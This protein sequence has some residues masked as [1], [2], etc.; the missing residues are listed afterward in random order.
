MTAPNVLV[1][2]GYGVNC[3]HETQHA[4]GLAG[5]KAE[6]V[7]VNDLIDAP[8]RLAAYQI[9][10][11]P[12]GFSFGDDIAAGR[13]LANKFATHLREPMRRFLDADKL[14][15]GVCNGFQ[16]MVKMGLIT[17]EARLME[18]QATTLTY[19]DSNRYEDRWVWLKAETSPCVFTRGVDRL[20]VPVAHGEGKFYAPDAVLDRLEAQ[21]Q[22]A[23]RYVAAD[24]APAGGAFP[25]N[26]NGSPRDIAGVCDA[27]GRVFGLMPHPERFLYFTNHPR[28]TAEADRLRRAGQPVPE[29]GLGRIVFQ[30]A[31]A[32]F[33]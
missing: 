6:R 11:F 21:G 17:P 14:V 26:P 1:L 19:N 28:W 29:E 23:L 25:A 33:A 16:V 15:I 22:V 7:H 18:S 30:N 32:Y 3:D 12:G 2:T 27:T 9:I 5:A 4:F 31:V 24:G 13:V 8:E 20:Y 10:A